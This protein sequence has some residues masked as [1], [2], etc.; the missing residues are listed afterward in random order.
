MVL[1]G[2]VVVVVFEV[3]WGTCKVEREG[4]TMARDFG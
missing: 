4:G 2:V 3:G 1:V